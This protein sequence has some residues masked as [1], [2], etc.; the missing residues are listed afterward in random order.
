MP[1]YTILIIDYEPRSIRR[2][3]ELFVGAGYRVEVARD[4]VTGIHRFEE[5]RPDLTLV[6][7][8]LPKKHG[9][10]VC[11]AL[12]QTDHGSKSPVLIITAVYKGRNYRWQARNQYKCDRY[13]EKPVEDEQLLETV[14]AFLRRKPSAA[15]TPRKSIDAALEP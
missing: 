13:I 9:F 3:T 14:R 15:D 8:M 12:K 11:L 6:E 7:A 4:G 10:D 1:D 2:L 5:V